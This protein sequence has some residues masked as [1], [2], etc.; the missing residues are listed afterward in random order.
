VFLLN[1]KKFVGEDMC[2]K[3]ARKWRNSHIDVRFKIATSEMEKTSADTAAL[4]QNGIQQL[5]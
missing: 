1:R 5:P 3:N 4:L 2:G